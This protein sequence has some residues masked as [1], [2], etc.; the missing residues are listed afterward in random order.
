MKSS[1]F[2]VGVALA[3]TVGACGK[4]EDK[5]GG[6]TPAPTASPAEPT[7]S[8]AAAG[9][10]SAAPEESGKE[11]GRCKIDVTGDLT[12][13]AEAVRRTANDTKVSFGTDYW[14]SDDELKTAMRVM[15]GL[16]DDKG[17]DKDA[18]VAEAMKKDPRLFVFIMNC[19]AGD[20][21]LSV[22][23]GKDSRYAD[24]PREPK[25]YVVTKGAKAGQF[26][27]ILSVGDA[28]FSVKEQGALE[29]TRFDSSRLEGTFA[30]D[31]EEGHGK[32]RTVKVAGTFA[33]DCVGGE[34]CGK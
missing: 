27:A 23:P 21:S 8:G 3:A 7:A 34:S 22:L 20:V 25:K 14:L 9:S 31:A 6:P 2:V 28:Y 16:G 1:R 33:F 19:G 17:V 26:S 11:L 10:G 24:I 12:A 30:F 15:V 5:A 32:K 29:V 13:S 18:K 4:G